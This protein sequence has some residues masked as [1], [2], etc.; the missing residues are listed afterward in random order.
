MVVKWH[1]YI[2]YI[3]GNKFYAIL[4]DPSGKYPAIKATFKKS[5]VPQEEQHRI[6]EN[7]IFTWTIDSD[8]KTTSI[9]FTKLTWS[10]ADFEFESKE[11]DDLDTWLESF[12][13]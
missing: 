4:D 1:G 5:E 9:E 12:K 3:R 13:D 6:E 11:V 7:A 8:K 2:D 10:R